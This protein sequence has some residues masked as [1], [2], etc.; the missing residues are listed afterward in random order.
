MRYGTLGLLAIAL[1]F[2]SGFVARVWALGA[3]CPPPC[4]ECYVVT[5]EECEAMGGVWGGQDT[6]CDPPP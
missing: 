2:L 4:Y 6:T 1:L 5:E 3:C